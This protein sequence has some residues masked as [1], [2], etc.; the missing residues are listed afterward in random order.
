MS[1][2]AF[3]YPA[4]LEFIFC[5]TEFVQRNSMVSTEVEKLH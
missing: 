5:V 3:S 1:V 2:S 4:V